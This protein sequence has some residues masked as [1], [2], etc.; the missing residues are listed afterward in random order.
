MPKVKGKLKLNTQIKSISH[1]GEGVRLKDTKGR[2]YE[3]DIVIVTVP[4]KVLQEKK[5]SFSPKLPKYKKEAI[6][7]APVWG[8]LKVFIEFKERF[9]PSYLAFPD[10]ETKHGQRLYFD[11]SHGQ[12]TSSHVLGLFAVGKQAEAYRAKSKEEQLSYILKEL[13]QVFDGRASKVYKKHIVQDWSHEPFIE[14]AYLADNAASWI[15]K[16]LSYTVKEKVFF[17]GEAYT[18]QGN[19]GSVHNA[20]QSARRVIEENI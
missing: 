19:W 3:A 20:T 13:D 8:G 6:A 12:E 17:A 16:D 14:S 15:A 18:E 5:L 11:A 1:G 7:E 4:L 10:S 9:Y 2:V